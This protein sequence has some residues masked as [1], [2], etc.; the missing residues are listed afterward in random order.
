MSRKRAHEDFSLIDYVK[1]CENVDQIKSLIIN[2]EES[3]TKNEILVVI[4]AVKKLSNSEVKKAY[5][6]YIT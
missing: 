5:W 3:I 1:K 2:H 4:D 6:G